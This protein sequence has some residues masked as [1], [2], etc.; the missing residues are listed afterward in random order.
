MRRMITAM[1][2]DQAGVLSRITSV[3]NRRQVNMDSVSVGRT[4]RAG[5]SQMTI[6]IQADTLAEVEQV[7]KQLNKQ[8]DVVKVSDITD[9][10]HL[11]RELA[12]IKVNAPA[13]TRSEI[14]AMIDPFRAD[15]VDVGLK[16]I[17]VQVAGSTEKVNA[18]IDVL[19]PYGIKQ[20]ARTGV[21]G[22]NRG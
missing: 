19:R 13:A 16:T 2:H 1:V 3:L 18:C 14:Q 5:E 20:L 7:T 22:F 12:L 8:I 11:E 6:I 21:T 17:V 9:E 10:P 4:E 15:V